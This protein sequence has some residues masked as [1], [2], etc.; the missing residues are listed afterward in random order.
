[1]KTMSRMMATITL[2]LSLLAGTALADDK[3]PAPD[4]MAAASTDAS[5]D[6]KA[7]T[8]IAKRESVGTADSFA[9][10]T[11]VWIWSS[12]KGA[13]GE[14]AKH[15][16]KRDGK[17]IWEKEFEVKSGRYRTWTRRKMSKAGSYTVEVQ[18]A[19]GGVIGS[20]SFT[21]TE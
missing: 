11:K 4:T 20:V 5:A 19:D 16:W 15:V 8:G 6:V 13:K 10:G 9:K 2:G 12:I 17:Q 18:N 1:M 21:V 7:G 14:Q 3:K